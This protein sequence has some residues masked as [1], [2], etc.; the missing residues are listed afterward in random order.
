[1]EK[2][3]ITSFEVAQ[4][5]GV[6][7]SAVSRTFT[8]GASVSKKTREK[9]L[10]AAN[11]LGYSPNAIARSLITHRSNMIGIVMGDITNPF[12]PEVL[13]AFSAKLQAI[14]RRVLLFSVG[15]GQDVDEALPLVLA[16]QVDGIIVTSATLSSAMAEEC[17][18]TGTP[19]VLFNRSVRGAEVCSV[20]CDNVEGGRMVANLLL[21]AGHRRLAFIAGK[22]N[23]STNVDRERGFFGRIED[24]G[25]PEPLRDG[26]DDYTYDAGFSAAKRLLSLD[27]RPD[28]IFC[29]NDLVAM[30][31]MDAAR[32]E[33]GLR[34]PE[35]VSIVGFDDISSAA[36][37]SY[38]LTTVRQRVNLMIDKTIEALVA[39]A[40]DGRSVTMTV[41]IAG[42]LVVRGSAKLPT[43]LARGRFNA[44]GF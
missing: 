4:L 3:R 6:S 16:Y 9:V 24:R 2:K 36:W 11:K 10:K 17:A 32:R 23:T 5:A 38:D 21:D 25:G 8:E 31:A 22:E 15:R 20:C 34:V 26:G 37:P 30:G 19:V 42:D 33:I 40:E 12:Y 29:A 27:D 39:G 44:S 28:G 1:M 18:K 14:D 7:Q 13:E 35:D 43:G 41:L